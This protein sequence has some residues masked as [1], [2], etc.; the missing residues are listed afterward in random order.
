MGLRDI[1][2]TLPPGFRF[3]P[4]DEELV[5]HYLNKKVSNQEVLKRTLVEIDLHTCE[6]WQLP[7]KLT[8]VELCVDTEVAKLNSTEWYFFSF[9]DRNSCAQ[10]QEDWVLCRVFHKSKGEGN[11]ELSPENVFESTA[12]ATS[13][14]LA[15][16]PAL[17]DQITNLTCGCHH[18]TSFSQSP[19][20]TQNNDPSSN[21]M[22]LSAG[23]PNFLQ[24]SHDANGAVNDYG[25][26]FD[27]SFEESSMGDGN[28][29]EMRFDDDENG[30][31]FL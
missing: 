18:F 9:R 21:L 2:A 29:K 23:N 27:M 6:P 28:L 14:A 30:L 17:T 3:Y 25:F 10:C 11:N 15:S 20:P 16:P 12:G 7:E 26:L 4:S 1:G 24:L 31:V 22:D 5:C 19:P 13:P 8:P